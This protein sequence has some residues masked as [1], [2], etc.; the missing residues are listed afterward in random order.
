MPF[1][2]RRAG[3]NKYVYVGNFAGYKAQSV[4]KIYNLQWFGTSSHSLPLLF[5]SNLNGFQTF[6]NFSLIDIWLKIYLPQTL[7]ADV[8]S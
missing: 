6:Y 7:P 1:T 8:I 3:T 5:A 2:S 4:V